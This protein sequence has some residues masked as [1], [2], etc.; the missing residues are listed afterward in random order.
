MSNPKVFEVHISDVMAFKRCRRAWDFSSPLRRN[1]T[2]LAPYVPFFTGRVV[3]GALYHHYYFGVHPVDQ[4]DA[5]VWSE[6]A[7]LKK[8]HPTIYAANEQT[9]NEQAQFCKALLEHYMQWATAY[10]GPFN[11]RTLDFINVEQAFNVPMRTN[12]NFI[13]RRIRKAGKFDGVVRNKLDDKLYLWEIKTTKSI[14]QRTKQLDLEEQAD[15][16]ALDVQELL[17]EPVAGIIYT[18]IRKAL[19]A[20]PQVL[21]AGGLSKNKQTDTTFE[22]YLAAIRAYHGHNATR[23]FINEHY[24]EYLQHLLDN[25]NPFFARVIV[26]RSAEQLKTARNELYAVAQEMI[27]PS[28]RI[29]K[30]GDVHCNWCIFREP[31]IAIQQ[32]QPEYAEKLLRENFVQNTY[33][34][35][36]DEEL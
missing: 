5:L 28:V 14:E 23:D 27:N 29:Y 2:P 18:L 7:K 6:T 31:C 9:I 16:Y 26:R 8:D 12:R 33:H 24:G 21:K 10:N 4:V 11:D 3:H 20:E 1:L 19:P 25:G 36:S 22:K 15:S 13:A 17:G 32:G 35:R 34:I 30:T